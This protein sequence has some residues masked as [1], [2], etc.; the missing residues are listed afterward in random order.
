MIRHI[1]KARVFN[2]DIKPY[3]RNE[4]LNIMSDL[5]TADVMITIEKYFDKRSLKQ[6]AYYW[7]VVVPHVYNFYKE[8][9]G[10]DLTREE[11]H[12]YH[13]S[14]IAGH[15]VKMIEV[16]GEVIISQTGKRTSEMN[17]KEFGEFIENVHRFWA[18]NGFFIPDPDEAYSVTEK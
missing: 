15:K 18:E 17:T 7:G 14:K 8:S 6:N 11:I 5:D 3:S 4:F 16:L 12:N 10:E 9:Y 13:L 2:R 1:F